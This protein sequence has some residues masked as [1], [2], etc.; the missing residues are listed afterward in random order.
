[1]LRVSQWIK[2]LFV[3]VPLIFSKNL[4][5][6]RHFLLALLGFVCF[7]AASSMVYIINDLLDIKHDRQHPVKKLRPIASGRISKKQASA[8][9][10]LPGFVLGLFLDDL[11]GKFSLA[12]LSYILL[13]VFYSLK[14]KHVVI[15]DILTIAAGFMLRVVAGA[16]VISVYVSSWL[17]LTTLFVS[18][19]LAIMKRRSELSVNPIELNGITRKVLSE[20]SIG[21]TEQLAGISASGVI[22]CYALYSVS[23][24]TIE[25]VHGESLV[26]TTI[27]VVF[28]IFRF[29]YLVYRKSKGENATEILLTDLPMIINAVLYVMVTVYIVY[30]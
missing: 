14:L 6:G 24:R 25:F 8:V 17:M 4:F 27:F 5:S 29:M 28:G 1:M 18:L 9:L 12:L 7:S 3:F 15:I 22:I 30:L 19:F 13:N 26:Y 20:Y 16:F 23:D 11:D 2:N 21:F 10:F